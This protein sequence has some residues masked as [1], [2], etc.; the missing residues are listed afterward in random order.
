MQAKIQQAVNQIGKVIL[1][2]EQEVKLAL[3]CLLAGGHLLIE[4]LPGMG[5]TTLSNALA[6]VFGLGFSRIQFTSDLLPADMLGV[7]IFDSQRQAFSFHPGPMFNQVVLADEINRASP[8]TQSALLEAMEEH[9]VSLDG[10][11]HALPSPFFV[12]GTQNPEHQAGTYPLPESQLDRFLM[13][14]QL[15]YPNWQAEKA[16]LRQ[17][18]QRDTVQLDSVISPSELI[19]LQQRISEVHGSDSILDYILRLVTYSRESDKFPSAL[20]PRASKAL[21]QSARS[22]AMIDNRD[23]LIPEDVQAVLPAVAEH[24]LRSALADHPAQT[25]LSKLLLEQVDPLAA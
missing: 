2:K 14:I 6:R 10:E 1:G 12:I 5:K 13:R 16:M 7:N 8:K 18:Q 15:G 17:P 3:T 23:Y 9:Q 19:Q 11:T 25:S 20:S 24:R 4:D 22:W 21:L